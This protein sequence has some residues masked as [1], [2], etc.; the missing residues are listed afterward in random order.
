MTEQDPVIE[1]IRE[2]RDEAR[3]LELA[4]LQI[5]EQ[6]TILHF[7]L[8]QGLVDDLGAQLTHRLR[9]IK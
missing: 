7:A 9:L 4:C 3:R 6:G 8:D 2:V 5:A 1:S